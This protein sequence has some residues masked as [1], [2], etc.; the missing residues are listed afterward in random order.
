MA[1]V[2]GELIRLQGEQLQA[3]KIDAERAAELAAELEP[4]HAAVSEAARDLE[5]DDEP[6]HFQRVLLRHAPKSDES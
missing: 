6:S 3:R 2:T 4:M 1:K 5:F